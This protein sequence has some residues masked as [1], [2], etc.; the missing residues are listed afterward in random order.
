MRRRQA[1]A[2]LGTPP[3]QHKAA[4]L[5]GHACAEAVGLCAPAVVRLESAFRHDSSNFLLQ[6]KVLRLAS[7]AVC[8]KETEAYKH[9]LS[10]S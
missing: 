10:T 6:T 5:R 7:N 3:L 2:T 1:P 8:V 4:A 9:L